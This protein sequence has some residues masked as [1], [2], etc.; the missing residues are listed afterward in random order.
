MATNL[1]II[2][3]AYKKFGY[4]DN[5]ESNTTNDGLDELQLLMADLEGQDIVIGYNFD[6]DTTD[7]TGFDRVF[8]SCIVAMLAYRLAENLR[9]PISSSLIAQMSAGMNTLYQKTA[10]PPTWKRPS[11][12]PRG[13]GNNHRSTASRFYSNQS[14]SYTLEREDQYFV[15]LANSA[16]YTINS[17]I[18]EAGVHTLSFSINAAVTDGIIEAIEYLRPDEVTW[19]TVDNSEIPF[20]ALKTITIDDAVES[21]RFKVSGYTG[22]S[23]TLTITDKASYQSYVAS[24]NLKLSV[25]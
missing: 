5:I 9:M 4:G 7:E 11:R 15:T 6:G 22:G 2:Q 17:I 8:D 12:M 10:Q 23:F 13:S 20:T 16:I 1:K 18:R 3:L 24:P 21:Y 14:S 25:V 19:R